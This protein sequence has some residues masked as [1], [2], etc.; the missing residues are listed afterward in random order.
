MNICETYGIKKK[1]VFKVEY[2]NFEKLIKNEI[3]KLFDFAQMDNYCFVADCEGS[4][5]STHSFHVEEAQEQDLEYEEGIENIREGSFYFSTNN[6]LAVLAYHK[7]IEPG[8][9]IVRVCW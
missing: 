8:E 9:Y 6:L 3:K 1:V 2:D 5:D 4:N 7:V